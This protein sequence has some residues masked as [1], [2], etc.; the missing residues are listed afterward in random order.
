MQIDEIINIEVLDEGETI[1][2]E[3]DGDHLFFANSILTHNS[4]LNRGNLSL[5]ID[6]LTE[7]SIADSW[8]K[9]MIA[10][11]AVAMAATPEERMNG[12][13]NFKT[14]KNRNGQ[15]DVIIP[16]RINYPC[17]RIDDLTKKVK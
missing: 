1:D 17:M 12:K 14:L 2:I 9:I 5:S 13:I 11:V 6:E 16:L 3:V 15:K 10:D 8:K 7:A 4:Q